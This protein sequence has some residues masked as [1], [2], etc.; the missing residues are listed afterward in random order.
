MPA[1]SAGSLDTLRTS[2]LASHRSRV[3]AAVERSSLISMSLYRTTGL[4]SNGS[5]RKR[6]GSATTAIVPSRPSMDALFMNARVGTSNHLPRQAPATVAGA[7]DT[8][9]LIAMLADIFEDTS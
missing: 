3:H 1:T 5:Q 6:N 4:V 2:A 8:T 9:L 7:Q